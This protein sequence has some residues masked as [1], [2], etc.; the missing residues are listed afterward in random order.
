MASKPPIRRKVSGAKH[1]GGTKRELRLAQQARHQHAGRELG[2]DAQRL[3]ARRPG[4]RRAAIEA[5]HQPDFA[6]PPAARSPRAGIR[7]APRCRYRSPAA[8]DTARACASS[9]STPT[10]ALGASVSTT[11]TSMRRPGNSRCR[12]AISCE[13]RVARIADAEEDFELG[14]ILRRVRE[15]GLVEARVAAVHGLEDGEWRRPV[16]MTQGRP[17]TCRH[18]A[19]A[20]MASR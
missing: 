5:R 4:I 12:R 2:G 17:R 14:I 9:A 1:H 6:D 7:A 11:T 16:R 8:A 3:R 18:R 20:T 13:R 19:A 15:D 10:L